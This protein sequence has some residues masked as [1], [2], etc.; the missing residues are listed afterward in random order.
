MVNGEVLTK[1][2][3]MARTM[4]I[5]NTPGGQIPMGAAN[6]MPP[7]PQHDFSNP[8]DNPVYARCIGPRCA[9]W[10]QKETD[11]AVVGFCGLA[12]VP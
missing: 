11:K 8:A 12:G 10:R 1:W 5:A 4:T 2:C 9:M 6:R 7:D 3:P